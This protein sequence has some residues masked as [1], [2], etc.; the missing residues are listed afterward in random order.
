MLTK[1]LHNL[2]KIKRVSTWC[3]HF[4]CNHDNKIT[5]TVNRHKIQHHK[6]RSHNQT[7]LKQTKPIICSS[8]HTQ[9][10]HTHTR[11]HS[12]M[13]PRTLTPVYKQFIT[14]FFQFCNCFWQVLHL[15]VMNFFPAYSMHAMQEHCVT[16][17][18]INLRR[19]GTS[20]K[21]TWI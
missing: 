4:K 6:S 13:H 16:P 1:Q 18:L 20:S 19:H 21:P 8:T 2:I 14:K 11:T 9:H 7:H 17:S 5:H 3:W 15:S 10:A 12:C